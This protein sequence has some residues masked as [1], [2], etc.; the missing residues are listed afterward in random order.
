MDNIHLCPPVYPVGSAIDSHDCRRGE[1]IVALAGN[2][3]VGKSTVFNALTGLRQHTG[4]WSGKT[5]SSSAGSYTYKK[6]V[7]QVMD[8]PGTYSLHATS[9]EEEIARDIIC[10]NRTDAVVVVADAT[11]LERNLNLLLQILDVSDRTV[12]CINLLD[13]AEKKKIHIDLTALERS[14]EIPV[15]GV[16]ARSGCGLSELMQTVCRVCEGPPQRNRFRLPLASAVQE[17]LSLI[18]EAVRPIT[19]GLADAR[20]LGMCLLDPDPGLIKNIERYLNFSLSRRPSVQEALSLAR[21]CLARHGLASQ[22]LWDSVASSSASAAG[23]IYRDCVHLEDEEYHRRDRTVDRILTSKITGIPIMLALLGLIFWITIT[24]A[25]LPSALLSDLLLGQEDA[26]LRFFSGLGLPD[27]FCSMLISG[28]Y[29]TLAWVVSV[30][31]P[32]MAVFFPLFTLLEDLGYLPR[33]AFNMDRLF[34]R[35][36]A[37]GK[38]VLTM[39]M[40]FGCNVCGVMGCRIIDSPRERLIAILTNCF[41]PCN[42]RFPT[43]V[44]III[45]FFTG[46]GGGLLQSVLSAV[47]LLGVV[48]LGVAMTLLISRILSRTILRGLPSSFILELPPYRMPQIGKVLLRSVLDRTL[49]VLG[50]AA[51]V[52]APAG[53]IIWLLANISVGDASLLAHCS[54]FLDPFGRFLGLD[55]MILLAFIL[56]F[57][58]NEIVFPIIIMGYLSSG[59]ILELE[60]LGQLRHLL[61]ENGWTW[62]TAVCT[63]LFS[64]MHFPCGTTCWTIRKETGSWKWTLAAF[65]LPFSVG[66]LVCALVAGCARLFGAA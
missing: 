20:W 9:A 27:L 50:R 25:N 18:E 55:G 45:M 15:V 6:T 29:R 43:L 10:F 14:L 61:Q 58:A 52:A 40:G 23:N 65:F 37:H 11:C 32:P 4:N 13:E 59:G 7:Y 64:L 34:Q 35:A 3:N 41:V 54:A 60:N 56:G 22:K 53:V 36:G 30:M 17:A 21:Q 2:P 38:Q 47:L 62:T 16:C 46:F 44:A 42:G 66:I 19:D 39:C 57:P 1:R 26:L 28:A 24:G 49:F 12:L 63:M 33:I 8:L 48:T 31:L 5:V 51:A